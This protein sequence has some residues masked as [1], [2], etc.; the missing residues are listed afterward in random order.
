MLQSFLVP[1]AFIFVLIFG[2]GLSSIEAPPDTR[3][4]LAV[5]DLVA[6]RPPEHLDRQPNAAGGVELISYAEA[7][8]QRDALDETDCT[9]DRGLCSSRPI[10]A[11][12]ADEGA[13]R[14]PCD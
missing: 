5:V 9:I 2:G 3:L 7:K 1:I 10:S 4:A 14:R 6:A 12:R 8:R 11:C 13:A